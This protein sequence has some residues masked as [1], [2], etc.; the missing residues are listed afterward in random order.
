MKFF[1]FNKTQKNT[2]YTYELLKYLI[3]KNEHEYTNGDEADYILVSLTSYFELETLIKARKIFPNK[4]IVVGGHITLGNP[5]PLL[6]WADFVNIGAG[7]DFF[8]DIKEEN[9]EDL[10]YILT[11]HKGIEDITPNYNIRWDEC[12]IVQIAKY[13][14]SYFY[15]TGCQ[16]KCSFCLTSWVNKY[17]K[18]N[19]S[20]E[21]I[22]KSLPTKS[23]VYLISNDYIG[24]NVAKSVTDARIPHFLKHY[25]EYTKT[26]LIRVG[27]E[28]PTERIRYFFRKN[29]FDEDIKEFLDLAKRINKRVTLF[30]IIGLDTEEDYLNW[31]DKIG[32]TMDA[33]PKIHIVVNYFSP[34]IGTPL[35]FF[36]LNDI[37]EI[38][39][40]KVQYNWK[41]KN[42]RILFFGYRAR[43][44]SEA[45]YTLLQRSNEENVE[46]VLSL[47][48]IKNREEFLEKAYKL[49]LE[50]EIE[51]NV[52]VNLK[53]HYFDLK[54]KVKNK[55][56]E[57]WQEIK[58][59]R[60]N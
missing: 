39:L 25:N 44:S 30:F 54:E 57:E 36:D 10:Q 35:E 4:K 48:D 60:F 6:R 31:I 14:Y 5:L 34:E 47:K 40:P 27:V 24:K 8:E 3:R 2:T 18:T 33:K 45:Y 12:P 22:R 21:V 16:Y 9:I 52:N 51:G 53:T 7:F 23:Q 56:K 46:K 29:V 19:K 37:L 43:W 11:A 38:N 28:S 17:Q 49:G 42:A 26:Q 15:S 50:K 13:S 32:A 20:E 59:E 55:L 1:L 41:R 58:K